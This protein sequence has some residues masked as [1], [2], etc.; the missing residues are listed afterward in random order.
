[1][2]RFRKIFNVDRVAVIGMIHVDALPG[3]PLFGGSV[4]RLI[5]KACRDA[6]VYKKSNVDGICIENMHDVPYVK[7]HE[8]RPE[9]TAVMS[10]VCAEVKRIVGGHIACGVQ[11]L[12]GGNCEALAVAQAA[13]LQF[14]RA[15]GFVFGHVG[16]EGYHDS[17]AG[18][19]LRYRKQIAADDVLIFTDIKKKHSS[20]AITADVSIE[21]TARAAEFFLSDGLIVTGT[22]TGDPVNQEDLHGVKKSSSLPVIVGSGTDLGNVQ[23]LSKSADAVIVGTYFKKDG[24]W[25]NEVDGERVQKFMDI[26]KSL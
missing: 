10:R 19:L 22:S 17:C 9:T 3:T 18:P 5:E 25:Q 8:L 7:S 26:V 1:M 24:R 2:L 12:A 6:Q 21:E 14:I 4:T 13:D 15:E 16:D 20:H 11:I 23:E